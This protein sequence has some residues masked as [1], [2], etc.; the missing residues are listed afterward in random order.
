MVVDDDNVSILQS[1]HLRFLFVH[2]FLSVRNKTLRRA[3][4]YA[5]RVHPFLSKSST[6][7]IQVYPQIDGLPT[8]GGNG[9]NHLHGTVFSLQKYS[10]SVY[11]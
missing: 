8:L 3:V 1:R 10:H 5:L 4:Q 11:G 9:G 6:K 2:V 7:R